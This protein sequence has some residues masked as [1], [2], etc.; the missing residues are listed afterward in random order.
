MMTIANEINDQLQYV[1][2]F[3]PNL[4]CLRAALIPFEDVICESCAGPQ[5]NGRD[6]DPDEEPWFSVSVGDPQYQK[7]TVTFRF[8]AESIVAEHVMWEKKR[9]MLVDDP[10]EMTLDGVFN[11]LRQLP[12][13]LSSY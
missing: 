12:R 11:F 1:R 9:P 3:A 10:R 6:Y 7:C 13:P 4:V 5:P 8:T 2:E